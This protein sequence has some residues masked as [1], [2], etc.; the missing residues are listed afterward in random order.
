MAMEEN[1]MSS[2]FTDMQIE[3]ICNLCGSVTQIMGRYRK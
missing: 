3:A 2:L 1:G